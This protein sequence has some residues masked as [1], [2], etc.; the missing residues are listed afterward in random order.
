M[1][2]ALIVVDLQ[3]DFL[4]GGSLGVTDGFRIV[5]VINSLI[6]YGK[7]DEIV[8]TQDWHPE[9]HCSFKIWPAHCVQNSNGA[10][11]YQN[12]IIRAAAPFILKGENK[13]VDS[14]SGFFDND[15][16]TKTKL[17]EFLRSKQIEEVHIVGLAL[18]YCVKFTALDAVKLG[19][20]TAIILSG[21]KAITEDTE[22]ILSE[23]SHAEVKLIANI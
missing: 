8:Y 19:F 7:Y 6:E 11:L 3:N 5:P 20:N 15:G 9:E 1:K 23:L 18:D 22:P 2:K 4:P 16:V 17:E 13:E 10:E 12:L 21:T 14:Y